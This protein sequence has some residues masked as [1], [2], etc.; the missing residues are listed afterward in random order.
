[1]Y[2]AYGGNIKTKKMANIND[3]KV[4]SKKSQ[5][6]FDLLANELSLNIDSPSKQTERLG[7]YLFILDHLTSKNDIL[8][9]ADIVTDE[10]FNRLIFRETNDD[11]G[12]DAIF[13]DN[14]ENLIQLFNFKYR[15]K[16]RSGKQQINETI[17]STKFINALSNEDTAHLSGKIKNSAKDI[18]NK[19]VSNDIW[20]LQ[21]YIVSNEEIESLYKD[22]NLLQL[23]KLYEL[24]TITIGLNE[25]SE[26]IS[27]RPES[28]DA[29]LILD[30]DAVMSFTES[31]IS[32]SKSYILRLP[33]SEVIRI[34]CK[35]KVL[36]NKYNIE[37]I[38]ELSSVKID[39]SVL[40]DNVRG[41]VLKSKF[42]KNIYNS[43]KEETSKFFMFN[44]GLTLT[45]KDI[46]ADS[47]NAKKKVRITLKSLQVLNGGQTLRTIHSFNEEDPK[48][49]EDYLSNG[50]ILVRVFKTS[51]DQ[52][53]NN[54]IAEYTNSQN[55]I[56]NIDL[57]S[58]RS[59]QLQLEQYLD[60]HNI[61]YSRKSGDTG[62]SDKKSY[63]HKISMERF[64][65]LLYSL[66]GFP[67]KATNQKKYIFDKYYEDVFG[68][69]SLKIEES[70]NVIKRYFEIKKEYDLKK[71]KYIFSDQ[72]AFYIL[73]LDTRLDKNLDEQITL[74]EQL[75][76][77][78]EP[79]SGKE[80]SDARKLI[81]TKFKEFIDNKMG[82][83]RECDTRLSK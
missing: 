14:E 59:E 22:E 68:K 6:Y 75:I 77:E 21:L 83:P 65:Q 49:I 38:S 25:I 74:F 48:N 32:S 27:L 67:E 42:N 79:V 53:L 3:Y 31:S 34:T 81:Q 60:E 78:Y 76:K 5:R 73:Y 30:N 46:I 56:S 51:L 33:L 82:I 23:E 9:I 29:E 61:I 28:V 18:I 36:R 26:Y 1:L 72:K 50:E 66:K 64:G 57:K 70:P 10:D 71:D 4:V 39:Y 80:I 35:N 20:K 16:F 11:Y 7:F 40:F 63:E 52:K 47:V 44:N 62:I 69:D 41:L 15:E 54:K 45:A 2:I 37:D 13:I 58:L 43:L 55:S 8:E 19:L 12:V 24:E 17:L